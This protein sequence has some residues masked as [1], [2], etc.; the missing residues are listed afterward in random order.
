VRRGADRL[1]AWKEGQLSQPD[2]D[3]VLGEPLKNLVKCGGKVRSRYRGI[4]PD[5]LERP[6]RTPSSD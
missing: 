4:V 1:L 2:H 3:S 6:C 5:E